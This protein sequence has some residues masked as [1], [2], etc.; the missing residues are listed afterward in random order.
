MRR[1]LCL[2]RKLVCIMF[3]E[4]NELKG[5]VVNLRSFSDDILPQWNE[6]IQL[7]PCAFVVRDEEQQK[8]LERSLNSRNYKI[9]VSPSRFFY[10][11]FIKDALNEL[12]LEPYQAAYISA[13][14]QEL[15]F[16]LNEPLGSIIINPQV[17]NEDYLG[18]MP[19]FHI[20]SIQI[21]K[22]IL[23]N[24]KTGYF[25]ETSTTNIAVRKNFQP[26]YK[27]GY[28]HVSEL[29]C[30]GHAYTL[31]AGGRYF[32][33]KHV[34]HQTHQ[35]SHRILRSKNVETQDE[36]FSNIYADIIGYVNEHVEKVDVITRVPP[37]PDK[38][39]RFSV[40]VGRICEAGKYANHCA[41]LRCITD[42]PPQKGLGKAA[43]I[44][45]VAGKYQA[46]I[47]IKGAHVVVIDDILTTGATSNECIK[48]LYLAGARRVTLVVLGINQF[49]V[50]WRTPKELF[51][52]SPD[53]DG[54]MVFR[55]YN[56]DQN[57]FFGCSNYTI[58]NCSGMNYL[59]GWKSINT[60]NAA[61]DEAEGLEEV[62]F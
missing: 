8:L 13:S 61:H 6:I 32:A 12:S 55:F 17:L 38:R 20:G 24:P 39:D 31:V 27:S 25:A 16:M 5:L 30:D 29:S 22:G 50:L 1:L 34:K 52:P 58:N 23:N 48:M 54:H 49:D 43:R 19:D 51:C 47:K 10:R 9:V 7:I 14:F 21:L 41:S 62:D 46:S 36:L 15:D 3:I 57:V 45:N 59:E 11:R 26:I 18:K 60:L 35:L 56:N 33:P 40:I 28:L 42:Y 4:V 44:E 37:R 53:C 2:R